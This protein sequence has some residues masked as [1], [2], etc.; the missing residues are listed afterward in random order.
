[1]RSPSTSTTTSFVL[2]E[3]ALQRI[4]AP[5]PHRA[6][7]LEP[8]VDLPQWVRT[9]P[10]ETTLRVGARLHETGVAQHSEMLGHRRLAD[11]QRIHQI[12]DRALALPQQVEDQPAIRLRHHLER[13]R[14]HSTNIPSRLY[15]CQVMPVGGA[16]PPRR[17]AEYSHPRAA[18]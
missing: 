11:V 4:E 2:V 3:V 7:R 8:R 12:S 1:M 9:H 10:V 18:W 5:R 6:I 17:Q 14:R 15:N 16:R 13:T